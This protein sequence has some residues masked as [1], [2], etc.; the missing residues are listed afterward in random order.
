MNKQ[1]KQGINIQQSRIEEL[2]T[3]TDLQKEINMKTAKKTKSDEIKLQTDIVTD[4]PVTDEQAEQTQGGASP[5]L[6]LHCA[7][8]QH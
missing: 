7:T 3:I 1:H 5:Y 8:G 4:L 2:K 6:F